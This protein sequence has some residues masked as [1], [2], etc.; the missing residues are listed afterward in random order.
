MIVLRPTP[1][2]SDL[3]AWQRE[4][5]WL[6]A[7]PVGLFRRD[8]AIEEAE[9]MVRMLSARPQERAAVAG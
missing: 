2:F 8:Q 4:L 6:R 5:D 7:Q 9:E 3:A 1:D